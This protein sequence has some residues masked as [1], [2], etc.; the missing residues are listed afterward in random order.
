[1]PEHSGILFQAG[2]GMLPSSKR[3]DSGYK[4]EPAYDT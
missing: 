2:A 1:L 3:F 4:P